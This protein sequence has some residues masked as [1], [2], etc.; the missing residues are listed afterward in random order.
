MKKF[1]MATPLK[2][3][4]KNMLAKNL[5]LVI[6][7]DRLTAIIGDLKHNNVGNNHEKIRQ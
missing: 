2:T 3:E 1:K 6:E 5:E 7:I 4:L